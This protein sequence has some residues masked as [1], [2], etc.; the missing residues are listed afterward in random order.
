MALFGSLEILSK[1]TNNKKL[2]EGIAYLQT[3]DL[4]MVFSKVTTEKKQTIEIDGQK[5]FAIFQEYTTKIPGEIKMEGHRKY[6]DIQ[7]I[8]SGEERI[9]LAN[10]TDIIS[11]DT[12]NDQ[13]DIHFPEV[14]SFSHIQL[15]KGDAAILYPDDLHGPCCCI[16]KPASVQKIVVKVEMG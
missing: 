11:A 12:Y 16:D 10:T 7:Y 14:K 5:I 13:K 4:D 1:Q 3:V 8:F 2:L 9:L 6:I 15:R